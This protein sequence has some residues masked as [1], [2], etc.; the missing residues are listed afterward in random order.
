[1]PTSLNVTVEVEKERAMFA[2][3]PSFF[4]NNYCRVCVRAVEKHTL[5][6]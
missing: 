6:V 2:N 4:A 3:S 1:M 5:V